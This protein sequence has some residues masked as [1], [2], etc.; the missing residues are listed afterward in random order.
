MVASFRNAPTVI[1]SLEAHPESLDIGYENDT[2][3]HRPK[4]PA[5]HPVA[6]T[7]TLPAERH[8]AN[9]Y[10]SRLAPGSQR[11]M[12]QAL[13]C[14]AAILTGGLADAESV[15]WSALR[16]QHT[17]AVRT[18]LAASYAPATASKMLSALRGVLREAWRLG[19]MSAE[20]YRRATDFEVVKGETLPSGRA[21]SAGEMAALLR[22]CSTDRSPAGA[23]D[24][25][26]VALLYSG[27]LRRSEAVA[28]DVADY[29]AESGALTIRASKGPKDRTAYVA[30]GAVAA[31]GDWLSIRGTEAGPLFVPINKGGR[32]LHSRM[33]GQ[34][35]MAVVSKRARQAA[36]AHLSP[37][38]FRRTF[39]SDLLDAGADITTVSKLAG[40]ANI[41]TTSRY[42]RRGEETKRKTAGLLHVPYTPRTRITR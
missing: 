42:D 41:A 14:I 3:R 26:L 23:R 30:N 7:Q 28:L 16:Y 36:V 12:R 19:L 6:L 15:D 33:T 29:D 34:A 4:A 31:L 24:A 9:V 11:T 1:R 32:I 25:A 39:V 27:G 22:V 38:D 40:H 17:Q 35:V 37:H 8:P 18:R 13:G 21:L 20:D 5:H 2:S 10:L